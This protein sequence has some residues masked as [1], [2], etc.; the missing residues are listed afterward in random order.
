MV[1]RL[2]CIV[3]GYGEVEAVPTLIRR[4]AAM[5][6][7]SLVIRVPQPIR[8]P[9]SKLVKSG[10]LERYVVVGALKVG[11][12]GAI[13]IVLDSDDDCPR[14]LGPELLRRATA[15][16]SD[17]SFGV[18]LAK[19]EFEAWFLASAESLQGVR[20]LPPDLQPPPD[21][22]SIRD[23]KGWL[24]N[25]MPRGQSYKET[26]HQA[27]LTAQFNLDSARQRSRSFDKCYREI[28]RL[29]TGPSASLG[30]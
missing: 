4:I 27:A 7:P 12:P 25:R 30:N 20:G 18:V 23:A 26:E 1:L 24:S 15:A 13:L 22:E 5:L 17:F 11:T 10:E 19:R 2:G 28:V 3:E 29:L 14:D 16:R 9:R 21:P 6:D 8:V